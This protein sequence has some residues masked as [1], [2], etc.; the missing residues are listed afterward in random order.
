MPI[1]TKA[2][3]DGETGLFGNKRVA[4]DDLRVEAYGTVDELNAFLGLVRCEKLPDALDQRL[5]ELQNTL[6]EVGASLATEGAEAPD[7][8]RDGIGRLERWIDE[9]EAD[10]A[11]LRTFVLPGGQ[12]ESALFHVCRTVCRRAERLVW[13]LRRR[14][15]IP[16]ALGIYLNRL[17]DL[18]FVWGR[19]ANWR[20]GRSDVPWVR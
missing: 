6:F 7:R 13:G 1:Y 4:K 18:M 14:D 2:G 5:A 11:P 12:R 15:R 20:H 8:V 3:D 17:S 9:A 16:D 10:L 19:H